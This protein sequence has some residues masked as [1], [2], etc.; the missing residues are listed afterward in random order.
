M[1]ARNTW[2]RVHWT[3]VRNIPQITVCNE[4]WW[5]GTQQ[6]AMCSE[7]WWPGTHGTVCTEPWSGTYH[8]S[9][10]AMNHDGEE[11]IAD[12][13]M[14]WTM[15]VRNTSQIAMCNEPWCSGTHR[16][17][18]CAMNH[19]QEHM[20]N[21]CAMNHGY[22]AHLVSSTNYNAGLVS[23]TNFKFCIPSPFH[24][25]EH[26][27]STLPWL[28]C[29]LS[30]HYH[31]YHACFVSITMVTMHV[32][33]AFPWLRCIFCQ[34]FHCYNAD[35]VSILMVMMPTLSA[36]PWLL[37]PFCQHFHGQNANFVSI[38]TVMMPTL[39]AFPWLQCQF[40]QHFHGYKCRLWP[41]LLHPVF[42]G[43][44]CYHRYGYTVSIFGSSHPW[45]FLPSLA[46]SS[47]TRPQGPW[48]GS[49]VAP[50]PAATGSQS[51]SSGRVKKTQV[52]KTISTLGCI[53]ML[54]E[55]LNSPQWNS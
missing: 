36:F 40:C 11:R 29:L 3:M 27:L 14:Q 22:N 18:Q 54:I 43:V 15:M 6:I 39:S 1:M 4:P 53:K 12:R 2:H 23:A 32:L 31:G 45:P 10:C 20:A 7:P 13:N 16:R 55:G 17:S 42:L 44:Y 24:G 9:Q 37:S 50:P 5:P 21:Q 48:H 35:F 26:V 41:A 51:R 30:H 25:T 38:W 19:G 47:Q 46:F 49:S 8:R 33:S 52:I 28:Q 34:H